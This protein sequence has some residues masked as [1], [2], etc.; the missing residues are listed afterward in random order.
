MSLIPQ[1]T[2]SSEDNCQQIVSP[3]CGNTP[4]ASFDSSGQLWVAF[5]QQDHVFVTRSKDLGKTFSSPVPVNTKPEKIYT[6]GENRPKLAFGKESQIFVSWT[7]KSQGRFTGDIRFSRSVNGGHSFSQPITIND[8]GLKTS[9]RFDALHVTE[10]GNIFISWL[11]KRDAV[12]ALETGKDYK[13]A[14]LYYAVSDNAGASFSD[15]Y[16]VAANSC[17]CCRIAITGYGSNGAA[18]MWRHIFNGTTRDHGFA[19]L[20][21]FGKSNYARATHDDWQIDAC[22]HHGPDIAA[23]EDYSVYHTAWFSNGNRHKG[24]YYGR[25]NSDEFKMTHE[26]LVDS[27]PG[28]GHPQV[29]AIGSSVYL[30]WK[31]FDGHSTTLK[32]IRSGDSGLSWGDA[33]T[34]LFTSGDSDHPQLVQ[35]GK[36]LYAAWHSQEEGYRIV[37][38]N[39]IC[40]Y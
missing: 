29:E 27:K 34:L 8:D 33:D 24:I 12:K 28:S 25:F 10:S 6:N 20:D 23:I 40:L 7:R 18:V 26:R 1:F 11:D 30:L 22:P 39:Y 16:K 3:A 4:S 13:G 38:L 36:K 2:Y 32:I 35:A 5:E 14:A 31:S 17:E 37:A 9:H 15:N 19:T 21:P